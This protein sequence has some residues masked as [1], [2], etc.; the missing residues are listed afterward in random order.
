MQWALVRGGEASC[1]LKSYEG[2]RAEDVRSH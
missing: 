2:F 1:A